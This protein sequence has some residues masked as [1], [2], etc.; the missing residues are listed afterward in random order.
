[1]REG[2]RAMG[3]EGRR[4]GG[5]KSAAAAASARFNRC[6]VREVWM[7]GSVSQRPNEKKTHR[8]KKK[9]AQRHEERGGNGAGRSSSTPTRGRARAPYPPKASLASGTFWSKCGVHKKRTKTEIRQGGRG[10]KTGGPS[11]SRPSVAGAAEEARR[12]HRNKQKRGERG[13]RDCWGC[14]WKRG[15]VG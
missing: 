12:T 4:D 10:E 6:G 14:W 1:M 5:A 9:A 2:G 13:R 8:G 7:R 11:F 3:R 15:G